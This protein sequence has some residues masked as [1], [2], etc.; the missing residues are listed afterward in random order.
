MRRELSL[1]GTTRHL[2]PMFTPIR[3]RSVDDQRKFLIVEKSG[4]IRQLTTVCK[5]GILQC[6]H[7]NAHQSSWFA[8]SQL[9]VRIRRL[10]ASPE[11]PESSL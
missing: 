11:I 8:T 3:W 7:V 1:V 2:W 4:E 5:I 9:A 6:T 10:P